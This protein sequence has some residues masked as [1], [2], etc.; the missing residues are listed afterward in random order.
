MS[1][2]YHTFLICL[3]SFF[4]SLLSLSLLPSLFSVRR[5]QLIP[6]DIANDAH[7][8]RVIQDVVSRFGRIDVLVNNVLPFFVL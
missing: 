4:S 2:P 8:K 5:P 6:G 7:C 3:S 1:G